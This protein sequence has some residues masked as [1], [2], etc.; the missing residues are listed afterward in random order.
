M[1]IESA[2]IEPA[3][4]QE[5]RRFSLLQFMMMVTLA[6]LLIAALALAVRLRAAEAELARLRAQVG[7][8]AETEPGQIAAVRAPSDEP[9]TYKIRL[10]VPPTT[11]YR[12]AYSSLLPKHAV[13][14][15]WYG[16]LPVPPGE[17][18]MTVKI[19]ADPRDGR[20][21]IIAA[22]ASEQGVRRMA[23]VLPETQTAV[24]RGSHDTIATGVGRDTVAVP[25]D[26]KLR[27]LDERWLV[28]DG[29]L[30]LYGDKPPQH[31]QLGVYAELQ[32]DQ[33]PL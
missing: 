2:E 15:A 10:R 28:G 11:K 17:S 25:A 1:S 13:S 32:P 22:V 3:R 26:R 5:S 6:M 19:A 20:W 12:V 9:L 8:L 31:D 21:K 14:P 30:L 23:T 7:Y 24:F 4:R 18:S 16:A 27:L 29:G 33:G